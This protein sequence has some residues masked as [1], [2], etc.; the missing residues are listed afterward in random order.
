MCT[1]KPPYD[2]SQQLYDKYK[3]A[4]DDYIRSTVR[5]P[6]LFLS[7]LYCLG[8]AYGLTFVLNLILCHITLVLL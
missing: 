6:D 7:P 5:K 8:D 2:Y 4:F 1:Q 3:E